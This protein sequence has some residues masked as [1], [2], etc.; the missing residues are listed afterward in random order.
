MGQISGRVGT[1]A[2]SG[3][4]E[5]EVG[6]VAERLGMPADP[7]GHVPVRRAPYLVSSEN[8]YRLECLAHHLETIRRADIIFVVKDTAIVER[9]THESLLELDG[10]Y[11]H[12]YQLQTNARRHSRVESAGI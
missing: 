11:H 10:V 2:R 8:R 7:G 3:L 6:F 4:G 1:R 9:G 5:V 12:L